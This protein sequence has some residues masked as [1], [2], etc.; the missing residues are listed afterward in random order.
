MTN[1][2]GTADWRKLLDLAN[3]GELTL[4]PE[5][6]KDLD[7][8]CERYL[9]DL[10]RVRTSTRSIQY[11]AGFGGMPSGPILESKFTSKVNGADS[12]IHRAIA[13]HIDQVG[14]M[15]QVFAKAIENYRS[16]DQSTAQ[17]FAELPVDGQDG[18]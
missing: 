13:T 6:G 8:K 15:R 11:V 14:L 18:R 9:D 4:D 2:T 10:D 12:S 7:A 16:V 1:A 17:R 5:I 3:S